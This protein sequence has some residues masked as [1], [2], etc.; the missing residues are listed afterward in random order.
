METEKQVSK[1]SEVGTESKNLPEVDIA[2]FL[3][4]DVLK[5]HKPTQP[6]Q[7]PQPVQAL[8]QVPVQAPQQVPVQT[9]TQTPQVDQPVPILETQKVDK[10]IPEVGNTQLVQPDT[11]NK[12][13]ILA[14]LNIPTNSNKDVVPISPNDLASS[15]EKKQEEIISEEINDNMQI[16]KEEVVQADVFDEMKT[17]HNFI[18]LCSY[19]NGRVVNQNDF[20][21]RFLDII[22]SYYL[23]KHPNH[24]H[25]DVLKEQSLIDET[26]KSLTEGVLISKNKDEVSQ[27]NSLIADLNKDVNKF[28]LTSPRPTTGM[29]TPRPTIGMKRPHIDN[30][31]CDHRHEDESICEEEDN[32][33][34][35]KSKSNQENTDDGEEVE[36]DKEEEII[37]E[38]KNND[39][40]KNDN[41]TDDLQDS[42]DP[43]EVFDTSKKK[44]SKP[45]IVINEQS[46]VTKDGS[47]KF[48]D[49]KPKRA[50]KKSKYKPLEVHR[51]GALTRSLFADDERL[52]YEAKVME[53]HPNFK[54]AYESKWDSLK[55]TGKYSVKCCDYC[56]Y[57]FFGTKK[58]TYAKD[59]DGKFIFDKNGNKLTKIEVSHNNTTCKQR[60][61]KD[62]TECFIKDMKCCQCG[63][64]P[65][66]FYAFPTG[67]HSSCENRRGNK[68][69]PNVLQIPN[70]VPH[71]FCKICFTK[72]LSSVTRKL[73]N[74]KITCPGDD[75]G[76]IE[77]VVFLTARS[78]TP[79]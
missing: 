45:K 46:I 14:P 47:G 42:V 39:S 30:Q 34:K 20:K 23:C 59:K 55:R 40:S 60:D 75:K 70:D 21:G 41:N 58:D 24:Q 71:H 50:R 25:E 52:I 3:E 7:V 65:A 64:N 10:P 29:K 26:L 36:D 9:L 13:S 62:V 28:Y 56:Q 5:I 11:I 27:I 49:I 17:I 1:T 77:F 22:T 35:K 57:I 6:V 53:I 74:G 44:K 79:N 61:L 33:P 38:D 78:E 37:Q 66:D 68:S 54:K 31:N 48:T 72:I 63:V 69:K 67:D 73:K 76:K 2:Q 18:A 8:Q 12:P 4:E 15:H 19:K 32:N 51:K 43:L 16:D